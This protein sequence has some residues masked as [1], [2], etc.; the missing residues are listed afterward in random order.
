MAAEMPAPAA[1][2]IRDFAAQM[3][4]VAAPGPD[5]AYVFEFAESGRLSVLACD[6]GERIA[7]SLTRF[8]RA[9]TLAARGA[10]LRLGGHD[11][12]LDALLR[13]GL[14]R[15]GRPVLGLD[16]PA[17]GFDLPALD[18]AFTALKGAFERIGA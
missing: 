18:T 1:A 3:G 15:E 16:R 9:D 8:V 14:T 11:A 10:V 12:G 5:G 6:G 7:V 2:A 17:R 13:A 4:L